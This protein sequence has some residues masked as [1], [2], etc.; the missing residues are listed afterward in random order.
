MA[1]NS[2]GPTLFNTGETRT[3]SNICDVIIAN[4]A[5]LKTNGVD[6]V[7]NPGCNSSIVSHSN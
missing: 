7:G 2:A 6:N 1:N 4:P 3:K 5:K